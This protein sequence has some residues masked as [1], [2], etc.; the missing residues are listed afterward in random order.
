MKKLITPLSIST[1]F[2]TNLAFADYRVEAKFYEENQLVSAPSL[3]VKP[4]VEALINLK[5]ESTFS[6]VAKE[7]NSN[8][9]HLNFNRQYKNQKMSLS[10][11]VLLNKETTLNI[12]GNTVSILISEVSS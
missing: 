7:V 2:F 1:L 10:T 6:V 5:D 4:E 8:I 12:N 11:S 9:V 3:V